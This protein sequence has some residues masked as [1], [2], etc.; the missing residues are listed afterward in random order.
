MKLAGFLAALVALVLL[1][2]FIF[3]AGGPVPD[4]DSEA[5]LPWRIEVDD[6]GGSSVFGLRFGTSTLADVRQRF[7]P[8]VAVAIIAVP[9]EAGTLEAYYERVAL[10]FVQG[11][12]VV[13][14]DAPA[15]LIAA[16]RERAVR[17][18][19]MEST[20]RRITLADDD[21][22]QAERLPVRAISVI[23]AANLDEPTL[24]Q[25][26]GT[27][28]ERIAAAEKQVHLL[29]PA[30]GLDITIDSDGKELLQYVAPRDFELLRGPLRAPA[31]GAAG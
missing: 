14:L 15:A 24:V 16:M 30:R 10:G 31:K 12:M 8:D 19:H 29:Y 1:L 4:A 27:P 26:F 7:G 28:V 21:L 18:K 5:N 22:A 3:P 9:G 2:P 6:Q 13:T 11:R 25:R 23:P 20:T 17:S